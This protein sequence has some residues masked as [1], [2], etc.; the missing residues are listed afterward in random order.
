MRNNTYQNN[1]NQVGYKKIN[2]KYM[3]L[4]AFYL[5]GHNAV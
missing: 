2:V 1:I 5:L 3:Q 4:E